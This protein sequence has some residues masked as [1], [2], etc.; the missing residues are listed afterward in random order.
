MGGYPLIFLLNSNSSCKDL[1]FPHGHKQCKN[2][3][4]LVGTILSPRV[5]LNLEPVDVFHTHKFVTFPLCV[6]SAVQG[7][8]QSGH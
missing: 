7:M 2:T 1:L 3:S 8:E 4:V 6:I 5:R